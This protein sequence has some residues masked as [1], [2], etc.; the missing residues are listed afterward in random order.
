MGPRAHSHHGFSGV[1]ASKSHTAFKHSA[2]E[3]QIPKSS[4]GQAGKVNAGLVETGG[5]GTHNPL[6]GG[7][8][9]TR[10]KDTSNMC[11][12]PGEAAA[13]QSTCWGLPWR[14][15]DKANARDTSS[16]PDPGRSHVPRGN[17]A[18]GP[19]LPSLR[20]RVREP[21]LLSPCAAATEA[22]SPRARTPQQQ[23][24]PR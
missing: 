21:Q 5:L 16:I 20:S 4:L 24:P 3:T 23:K 19:H 9:N 14:L 7:T 15:R 1:I 13:S 17:S 10:R 11:I 12:R 8:H 18:R 2:R 22:P 6:T